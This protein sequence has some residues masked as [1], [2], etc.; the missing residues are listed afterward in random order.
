MRVL[1][2][3][4]GYDE[5]KK[6]GIGRAGQ[7]QKMALESRN[8]ECS[9]SKKYDCDILH[10]NTVF[11]ASYKMLKK[12]KK[13]G[14]PVIVHGH[15]T[16]EDFRKSFR[17]WQV[18]KYPFYHMLD[19]MYKN[20]DLIITPTVY[21][22]NLIENYKFVSCEVFNVSNGINLPDYT[23]DKEKVEAFK[24]RFSIK[25]NEKI[26]IGIGL[27][28]ERKG[29]LDFFE[30]ASSMPEVKFIWFGNL[31]KILT[32]TKINKAIKH[33]PSNVLMPGYISGDII[34]GAL[35]YASALLFPSYEETEGIVVLEGLAS[36]TPV[37]VRNI[38]V[39]E[40]WL[41]DK[42]HVLMAN[43]NKQFIENINYVLNNDTSDMVERGYEVVKKRSIEIVGE[44]LEAI[45]N[46]LLDKKSEED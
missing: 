45:Y 16:H 21:S 30:I 36:K 44:Q 46:Y 15:S 5:L 38:G 26:I 39:Y 3:F 14:I 10:I 25:E 13:K 40:E 2:Y 31:S 1:L 35:S 28:F 12:A 17:L 7:H 33:R 20:A 6:S 22:K 42:N 43:N 9:F 29:L 41:E 4:E 27:L 32:Q 37:L 34:K 18:V 8:I 23:Y 24:D 11:F 19:R